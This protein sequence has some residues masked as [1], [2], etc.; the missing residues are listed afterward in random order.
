MAYEA[1][2]WG[3]SDADSLTRLADECGFTN[4]NVRRV[5]VPLI[6][7]GGPGQLLLTLHASSVAGA[8]AGLS[9]D[10]RSALAAALEHAARPITVEGVVNSYAT[11]HILTARIAAAPR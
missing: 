2:P 9:E 8:I 11:S 3:F 5:E 6:F 4:V 7:E 10:D 1:G